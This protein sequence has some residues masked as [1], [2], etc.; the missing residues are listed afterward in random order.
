MAVQFA[1]HGIDARFFDAFEL[2]GSVDTIPGYDAHGR[3]R[4]YGW[5]LSRGEVG[6]YLSHRAAWLQ[7]VQS[8]NETM[9][10][11]ED[12]I[13][14]LNGFKAATEELHDTRQHWDMVRLMWINEREQ[15][16]YARLPSGSRLMWME[17]PVGTQSYMI[18]RAAARKMLAY[19]ATITHPIDIAFDRNWE[20]GQRM[21]VTSPQF[22]A[23]TR[24]PT[25]I[26]DRPDT[27]TFIQRLKLKYYRKIERRA[28]RRFNDAHRPKQPITIGTAPAT[29]DATPTPA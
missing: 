27:R 2:K 15:T 3:R 29:V 19:T 10:V 4:R 24:A 18:T 26:T 12:D 14:L 16:E 20:H 28:M 1:N 9:C 5:P 17:S 13:S 23:D 21:Y 7:L 25:M 8:G 11:M 22:A 6:C